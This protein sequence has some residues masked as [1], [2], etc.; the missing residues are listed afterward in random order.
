LVASSRFFILVVL[1][2]LACGCSTVRVAYDNADA[3]IRWQV[4]S[5]VVVEGA[6][7]DE[8]DER[9]DEFH[10]WHRKNALPKY[11]TLA[12][13]ATQRFSDG[14]SHA[15]LVWGYDSARAQARES[16][17]KAAELVA[18]LL[19]RLTPEQL[20]A[21]ERRIAEENRKFYRDN[22][23][24]SER[25]RRDRRARQVINR[26]EDWVGKLTQAQVQ[27]VR[28]YV[29]RAPLT[30]ELR[31]RDRKRLQ[32]DVIAIVRAHEAR[33][34]L[35]ERVVNW[36]NGR[37]PAVAAGLEASR[38]QYFAMLLDLDRMLTPEQRARVLG[39]VRRYADD[40]DALSAQ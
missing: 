4:H 15:D 24:G 20:A 12:H 32:K 26:L 38:Q 22:L 33:A 29:E 3:Y 9:I 28:Q 39:Q 18:P 23:R 1:S 2:A 34:R 30:D 5:Y 10:A 37:E 11:V 36:E 31:D 19:D 40:F 35:P 7:A 17:R 25:D 13:E 16:L 6:D 27:R 21:M 8:L 14:L